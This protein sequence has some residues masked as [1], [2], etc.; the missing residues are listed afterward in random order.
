MNYVF[1]LLGGCV[2]FLYSQSNTISLFWA[3]LMLVFIGVVLT[4]VK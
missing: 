2:E 4:V 3:G 1:I